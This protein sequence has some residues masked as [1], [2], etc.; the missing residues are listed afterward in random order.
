MRR[1]PRTP[2][3]TAPSGER[4]VPLPRA[5]GRRPR[6]ARKVSR[7]WR[8][9]SNISRSS[10][11][12]AWSKPSRCRMPCV[13]RSSSSSSVAWPASWP[14][15]R[16][17]SGTARCHRARPPGGPRPSRPGRSSSIG[18]LMT[19]VGPVRSIHCTCR[20]SHR[21]LVHQGASKG[22]PAG[23]PASAR[24]RSG[25]RATSS[26]SS[27][28]VVGLVEHV[29]AHRSSCLPSACSRPSRRP[30]LRAGWRRSARRRRR[31]ALTRRCRTTSTEVEL[32]EVDVL[33]P[34]RIRGRPAARHKC[35]PAGRPA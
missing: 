31:C 19:S 18:K 13:V 9:S 10:S 25:S 21:R 5:V 33:E 35:R 32:G 29:D 22:R 27:S 12:S 24:G 17:R 26:S 3:R 20:V 30:V 8:W 15:W 11:G 34:S 28:G 16:R 1:R 23:G 2:G 6:P 4:G 7:S 14:G